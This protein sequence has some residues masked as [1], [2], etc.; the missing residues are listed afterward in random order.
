MTVICS[1]KNG[2]V[3]LTDMNLMF[4]NYYS[5]IAATSAKYIF[6]ENTVSSTLKTNITSEIGHIIENKQNRELDNIMLLKTALI[7]YLSFFVFSLSGFLV[8]LTMYILWQMTKVV[9][10]DPALLF[11]FVLSFSTL[12]ATST[13]GLI[14]V[15]REIKND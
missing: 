8:S 13:T 10:I 15:T 7:R 6:L 14:C 2:D 3:A 12:T 4:A 5:E 9:I 11:L 1:P